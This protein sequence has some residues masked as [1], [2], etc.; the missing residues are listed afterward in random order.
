MQIR[1]NF[2]SGIVLSPL[3]PHPQRC[4][5]VKKISRAAE[6]CAPVQGSGRT[7]GAILLPLFSIA[8]TCLRNNHGMLQPGYGSALMILFP[9]RLPRLLRTAGGGVRPS[10]LRRSVM[11]LRRAEFFKSGRR[12]QNA[13]RMASCADPHA[14][15]ARRAS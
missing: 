15:I 8:W 10:H 6:G 3:R 1:S 12:C 4:G 9:S 2:L 5:K 13:V 14:G 7:A 11:L